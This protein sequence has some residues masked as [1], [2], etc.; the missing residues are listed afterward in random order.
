MKDLLT[1]HI[2]KIA[3]VIKSCETDEHLLC[4][5]RIINN[6]VKYWRNK[7]AKLNTYL[8]YF[9]VLYNHQKRVLNE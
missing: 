8:I 4:A 1:L 3:K 6:F 5:K 7:T 9:S 2:T